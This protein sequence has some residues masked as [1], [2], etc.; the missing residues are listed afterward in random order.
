MQ[1]LMQLDA[2]AK[3]AAGV[4]AANATTDAQDE[5]DKLVVRLSINHTRYDANDR[6]AGAK[7]ITRI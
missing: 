2:A 3:G 5:E 1:L 7:S 4:A 6:I